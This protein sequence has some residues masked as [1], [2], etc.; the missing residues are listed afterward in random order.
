MIGPLDTEDEE[1]D[2]DWLALRD[3]RQGQSNVSSDTEE[4][5]FVISVLTAMSTQGSVGSESGEDPEE[6]MDWQVLAQPVKPR[7]GDMSCVSS[8]GEEPTFGIFS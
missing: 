6:E 5:T 1:L 2:T 3:H 7:T 4:P 8:A